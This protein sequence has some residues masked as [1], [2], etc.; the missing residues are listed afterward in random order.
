[1]KSCFNFRFCSLVVRSCSD[2][3]MLCSFSAF[4]SFSNT[5]SL[6]LVD[7]HQSFHPAS[8]FPLLILFRPPK[9]CSSTVSSISTSRLISCIFIIFSLSC[10]VRASDSVIKIRKSEQFTHLYSH[11]KIH[12]VYTIRECLYAETLLLKLK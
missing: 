8:L 11:I 5:S 2:N 1:M 6:N 10:K 9:S 7:M 3:L 4:S 12:S